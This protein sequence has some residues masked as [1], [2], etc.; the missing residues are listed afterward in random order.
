LRHRNA[1]GRR[2][3]SDDLRAHGLGGGDHPLA[4]GPRE[5][6]AELV[7]ERDELALPLAPLGAGLAVAPARH[8]GRLDAA[9]RAGAQQLEVRGR[10]RTQEEQVGA[11]VGDLGEVAMG[12]PA[13]HLA[14]LPRE[15]D[16]LPLVAATQ[17]VV[18]GREAELPRMA[19]DAAHH[20]AAGV[21]ERTK[22]LEHACGRRR[23]GDGSGGRGLTELH[24]RVD[25]D[26][27][28]PAQEQGVHVDARNVGALE[29]EA[30]ETDEDV[31]QPLDVHRRVASEGAEQQVPGP[32]TLQH[33]T[34]LDARERRGREDHV[35][36]GLGED[37]AETE[38]DAGPELRIAHQTRDELAPTL[39][40]LGDEQPLDAV[41]GPGPA[42]QILGGA[43]HGVAVAEADKDQLPFGLVREAL[44]AEL[45]HH[46]EAELL[47][48]PGGRLGALDE[49]LGGER[50]AVPGEQL[51]RVVLGE[52]PGAG[53][54]HH[55][56]KIARP[57]AQLL[58]S[59]RP[60]PM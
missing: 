11:G 27:L 4:I 30:R 50:Q 6:H 33:A 45:Q 22:A 23:R 54:L 46:G 26:R 53:F 12:L 38:G 60:P 21:E 37:A 5:Q 1:A 59:P 56:G 17:Q 28:G 25:G 58:C 39:D 52:Q 42:E 40:V 14:P 43:A 35:T 36:D 47:G 16:Q 2:V 20:D 13:E 32:Q 51:L 15:R 34:S 8:E 57:P 24:Q 19:R 18:E 10:G 7:G 48:R 31:D 3:G 55:G 9:L 44:A 41:F 49:L 29:A